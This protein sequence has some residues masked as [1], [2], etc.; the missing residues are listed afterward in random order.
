MNNIKF[1]RQQNRFERMFVPPV[2]RAIQSDIDPV[3]NILLASGVQAA[4]NYLSNHLMI[5]TELTPV[6]IRLY[7]TV[8]GYWFRDFTSQLKR[9]KKAVGDLIGFGKNEKLNQILQ[10]YFSSQQ[11]LNI[12]NIS[13]TTK[14]QI[15]NILI[16][17]Q[18]KGL[19]AAEMAAELQSSDLTRWRALLIVRTEN[20]KA[21]NFAQLAAE[22]ESDWVLTRRWSAAHDDR[23]RHSH[24]EVDGVIIDT[25]QKFKVPIYKSIKGQEFQVGT[26]QMTGPGDDTASAGNICNCR[27]SCI[28]IHKRDANGR[29]I[30]KSKHI[31]PSVAEALPVQ[32]VF[33]K[34]FTPIQ[35]VVEARQ[36]LIN[37]GF[38]ESLLIG[39]SLFEMN[40]LIL[41]LKKKKV[42]V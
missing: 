33:F 17:G 34:P 36:V 30:P 11:F 21:R 2:Y 35:T 22:A 23:T 3:V 40:Q 6:L 5:N 25:D 20:A 14:L 15:N 29:L 10:K 1:I 12:K 24:R 4:I 38:K 39:L 27:C 37:L 42:R 32:E 13:D 19:G 31:V 41:K 8:G 28:L 7:N 18:E 16:R 26:D 9:E